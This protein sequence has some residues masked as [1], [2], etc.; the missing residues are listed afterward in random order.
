M[1]LVQCVAYNILGDASIHI[2]VNGGG[3]NRQLRKIADNYKWP[4]GEKQVT[5]ADKDI[6]LSQQVLPRTARS[7]MILQLLPFERIARRCP[8]ICVLIS[9][10]PYSFHAPTDVHVNVCF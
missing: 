6:P 2:C 9:L 5:V 1:V 8:L 3:K 4:F 7:R 10:S